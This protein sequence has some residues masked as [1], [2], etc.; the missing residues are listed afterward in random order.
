MD[1]SDKLLLLGTEHGRV[2]P[3]APRLTAD[4]E[5]RSV[6]VLHDG[7]WHGRGLLGVRHLLD[8]A[9]VVKM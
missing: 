4:G 3:E 7:P 8:L 6:I 5:V 2:D 1:I 9:P